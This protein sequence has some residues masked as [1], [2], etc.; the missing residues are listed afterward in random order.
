M[1]IWLAGFGFEQIEDYAYLV[2]GLIESLFNFLCLILL[3][4]PPV[5]LAFFFG[6]RLIKTICGTHAKNTNEYTRNG[7]KR[8]D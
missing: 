8:V 3:T 1:I 2:D 4:P 5:L 6:Y 7:D